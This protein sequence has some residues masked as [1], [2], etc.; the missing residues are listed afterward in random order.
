MAHVEM[1]WISALDA[2]LAH[3][4]EFHSFNLLDVVCC[5]YREMAAYQAERRAEQAT[6][7]PQIWKKKEGKKNPKTKKQ[8][9]SG[10]KF[11]N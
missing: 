4:Y 8:K 10:K 9:E 1:H 2:L 7:P 11:F 5:N 3:V 6:P